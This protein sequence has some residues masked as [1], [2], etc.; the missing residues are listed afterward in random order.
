MAVTVEK[1]KRRRGEEETQETGNREQE[2]GEDSSLIPHPSSLPAIVRPYKTT[3]YPTVLAL[4]E[5][6]KLRPYLEQELE[7]LIGSGGG[8]LV[9]V[10]SEDENTGGR[11]G[12]QAEV[13]RNG[14]VVGVILW[15]HNGSVGILWRL[16]V[17]EHQRGRGIA[18]KLL[19]RAEQDIYEAGLS[20]VTLLTRVTNTVAKSMYTKRGYKHNSPLEFWGKKLPEQGTGDRGQGTEEQSLNSQLPGQEQTSC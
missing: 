6:A 15:S 17:A 5:E 1:E 12:E 16:A 14:Q 2:I 8:A 20:G 18:T 11:S 4:W 13:S 10:V 3:D 7:R 19:D 9:A